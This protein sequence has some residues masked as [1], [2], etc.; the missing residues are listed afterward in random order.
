[1]AKNCFLKK[2]PRVVTEDQFSNKTN[3]NNRSTNEQKQQHAKC[4]EDSCEITIAT[5][6]MVSIYIA[7]L[8]IQNINMYYLSYA[9]NNFSKEV[10][11]LIPVL[12]T[13]R[14]KVE[15]DR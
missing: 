8:S 13:R 12:Q 2:I 3:N 4:S 10:F 15:A 9:S 11:G 1:M 14:N 7:P 5:I 6:I